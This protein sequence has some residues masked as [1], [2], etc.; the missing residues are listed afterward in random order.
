MGLSFRRQPDGALEGLDIEY[1]RAFARWLGVECTF[2]EHPWDQLTELLVAGRHPG[3]APAD[4]VWSALP[5]SA[6]YGAVA[7]SETYTWLPFVLARR[8]GD[9]RIADLASLEGKVVGLINDPAAF[10]VLEAA[11]VR[12]QANAHKAGGRVRLANLVAYSDQGRIH[13]CLANGIVDAFCV[14]L[15]IYHWACTAP[16][17]PWH[18]RLEILPGNLAAQPY[19]YAVGVCADAASYPLLKAINAFLAEFHH[20][21]E[22]EALERRWQGQAWPGTIS[23]RDESGDLMGEEA[24]QRLAERVGMV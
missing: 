23:Y 5:P 3:E 10:A 24:L 17:S 8:K 4:V 15:P 9:K 22:R 21:P 7:Y 16:D 14:D 6:S 2:M 19:Y 13:D 20:K 11:G 18:G 1:A 12:W